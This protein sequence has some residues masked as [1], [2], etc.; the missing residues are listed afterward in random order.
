M[1]LKGFALIDWEIPD[2]YYPEDCLTRKDCRVILRS[3]WMPKSDIIVNV[4]YIGYEDDFK[5]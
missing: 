5:L 2:D 3:N 1:K 4:L